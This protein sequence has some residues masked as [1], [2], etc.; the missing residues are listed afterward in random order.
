ME[1]IVITGA[2]S[3]FGVNWLYLLDKT[4][5]CR[6]FVLGRD[7]ARFDK[8]TRSQP[9]QNKV[10]FIQCELDSLVSIGN[11]VDEIKKKA[12]AVD[13]LI[14]NAGVWS[15]DDITMSKD[16]IELT[17]AVNQLAPYVLTGKL[18]PLLKKSESASIINTASFR[19]K[20]A[21]VALHDIELR[22]NFDAEQAYCNSKLYTVL[23]TKKLAFLLR[24]RNI[25]VNCFDPGIVD[26]PMLAQAFPK[27]LRSVFPLFKRLFAR[28]P[29]KGAETGVFLTDKTNLREATLE[30]VS[31]KK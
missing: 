24:D 7:K 9:L 19:H 13:Y 16:D 20:D 11:T 21:K 5:K 12:G 6:F 15:S 27:Y 10:S 23:F 31:S 4:K 18:L 8:L 17:L 30:T 1:N 26:T 22:H 2:T 25:S 14:N 28:T 29:D 3:G